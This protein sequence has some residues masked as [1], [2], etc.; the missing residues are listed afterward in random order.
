LEPQPQQ[1]VASSLH[2]LKPRSL[3]PKSLPSKLKTAATG[4]LCG[5]Q[6][7]LRQSAILR[8]ISVTTLSNKHLTCLTIGS[9]SPTTS[10]WTKTKWLRSGKEKI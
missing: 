6:S 4:Y 10:T 5:F 9:I 7:Q 1:E 3:A 2:S 8:L